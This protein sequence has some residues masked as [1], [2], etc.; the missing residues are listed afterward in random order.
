MLTHFLD[1]Y[2][3]YTSQGKFGPLQNDF[4]LVS[5][6]L[7]FDKHFNIIHSQL[8]DSLHQ[9]ARRTGLH[10]WIEFYYLIVS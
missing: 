9:A 10:I 7:Y 1:I 5:S 6:P 8:E 2:G 4:V 3:S